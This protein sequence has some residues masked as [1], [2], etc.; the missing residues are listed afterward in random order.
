VAAVVLTVI[1]QQA[2]DFVAQEGHLAR[3]AFFLPSPEPAPEPLVELLLRIESPSD[4]VVELPV[5]VVQISPTHVSLAFLDHGAARAALAPL[6]HTAR[7]LPPGDG[8]TWVFWGRPEPSVEAFGDLFAE[9]PQEAPDV[10][11]AE[12]EEQL[13]YDQIKTMGSP[14]KMQ[15]ALHGDRT[16]RFLLLKDTNRSIQPFLLQ[17]PR[18]TMDEIRTIAAY[19]QANPEV[20]VTIAGHRDWGQNQGVL[21]ALARNPKTPTMTAVKLLEKIAPAELKRLAKGADVPRA[22]QAAARKKVTD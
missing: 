22:V 2:S 8:A 19:R 7:S 18:I 5:R 9:V 20:L 1:F 21:A 11:P 16:A 14:E 13:L 10:E 17:N 3:G 12:G 15:L 6:F 4:E